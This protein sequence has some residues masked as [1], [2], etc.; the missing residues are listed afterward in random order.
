VERFDAFIQSQAARQ[1]RLIKAG[2]VQLKQGR[3]SASPWFMT[4]F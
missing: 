3:F 4:S 1:A 2:A